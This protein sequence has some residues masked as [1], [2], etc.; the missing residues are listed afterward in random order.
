[1]SASPDIPAECYNPCNEVIRIAH[2]VGDTEELCEDALY[3]RD[4][5][6][7]CAQCLE[8]N[9]LIEQATKDYIPQI[10]PLL[11][12]CGLEVVLA[13]TVVTLANGTPTSIVLI[14]DAT[15]TPL[16]RN[17]TMTSSTNLRA[18]TVP[19]VNT[20]IRTPAGSQ[21]TVPPEDDDSRGQAW[22][23][24]PA[25]GTVAAV[26]LILVGVWLLFRRRKHQ[27]IQHDEMPHEKAQLHSDCLP[28]P[29]KPV[30]ELHPE[31]IQELEGSTTFLN[32]AEKPAN[33]PAAPEKP[34]REP[35]AREK[36]ANEPAAPERP[37]NEP[38]VRELNS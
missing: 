38:P 30:L 19:I 18:S 27:T 14:M 1:M 28:R 24:G 26:A 11:A 7:Q 37:A 13:T 8:A 22:I 3:F 9:S 21:T 35:A 16:P 6:E 5:W 10:I 29:E 32:H 34:A 17:V 12:R 2:V 25:V 31:T 36:P 33:E 4:A 20:P 23:A 15:T